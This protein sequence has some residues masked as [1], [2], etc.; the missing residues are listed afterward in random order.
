VFVDVIVIVKRRFDD[1]VLAQLL[2]L[3]SNIPFPGISVIRRSRFILLADRFERMRSGVG[4]RA[5][6][7]APVVVVLE[8]ESNAVFLEM[9]ITLVAP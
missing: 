7:V 3:L 9:E 6:P 2:Q 4:G 8:P 1:V 5:G